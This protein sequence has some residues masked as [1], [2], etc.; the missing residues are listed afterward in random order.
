MKCEN[1]DELGGGGF[2]EPR[3]RPGSGAAPRILRWGRLRLRGQ[4]GNR[5]RHGHA[6]RTP[7]AVRHDR[8]RIRS[9]YA[10]NGLATTGRAL[11]TAR[12]RRGGRVH[13]V[14]RTR[15]AAASPAR[16]AAPR[17][18]GTRSGE[19]TGVI[20]HPEKVLFPDDGIT[21]GELA[22]YYEA[23][24]S[25]MLPHLRGRPVTMERFPAGITRKG[26]IQKDV[27]KLAAAWVERVEVPKKGGSSVYAL[28]NDQRALLW[29]TNLNTITPHVWVRA[30][31]VD[32]P[33]LCVFDLDPSEDD[34]SAL[35]PRTVV[36]T[37]LDELGLP[38]AIK[39]SGSKGFTSW[40]RS[41]ARPDTKGLAFLMPSHATREAACDDLH[42]GVHQGRSR[43]SHPDRYRAQWLGRHV[44]RC[45]RRTSA[46]GR[47]G[48][49]AVPLGGGHDRSCR[50]P[51]LHVAQR[52]PAP[53]R[54]RRRMGRPTCATALADRRDR[55]AIYAPHGRRSGAS[56]RRIGAETEGAQKKTRST[57]AP[58]NYPLA[59]PRGRADRCSAWRSHMRRGMLR[60][61][62]WNWSRSRSSRTPSRNYSPKMP[63]ASKRGAPPGQDRTKRGLQE[64][65]A[66][67]EW[68]GNKPHRA[69]CG[70]RRSVPHYDRLPFFFLSTSPS[71]PRA[72]AHDEGDRALH[73]QRRQDHEGRVF[74]FDVSFEETATDEVGPARMRANPRGRVRAA[75][76]CSSRRCDSLRGTTRPRG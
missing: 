5:P 10:G 51:H 20:T 50:P 8:N 15:Q 7:R 63:S 35:V 41:T 29:M 55:Q 43:R 14:D 74:L 70:G 64:I 42:A 19:R 18:V 38:S 6:A 59:V 36:R 68:W 32:T 12:D 23:V 75:S 44:R 27:S 73:R 28:V 34:E 57:G 46:D 33:D 25:V 3:G 71:S 31:R 61:A 24:A 65:R 21:K 22:G 39:T 9:V 30:N 76:Q 66:K 67:G 17:Q 11:G 58:E 72:S 16:T 49:H 1:S 4:G 53:G 48:L 26:F 62:T 52:A 47:A 69:R 54:G 60:S 56:P 37:A 45:L 40:S 2:T 13:G